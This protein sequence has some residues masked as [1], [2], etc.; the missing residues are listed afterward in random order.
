MKNSVS[1]K[2]SGILAGSDQHKCAKKACCSLLPN[3]SERR[4]LSTCRS[5]L[6]H[7][8][9]TSCTLAHNMRCHCCQRT[10][11][12]DNRCSIQARVMSVNL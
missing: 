8:L 12:A 2:T 7:C 3:G 10:S 1:P 4:L 11:A 6:F 9:S 5:K